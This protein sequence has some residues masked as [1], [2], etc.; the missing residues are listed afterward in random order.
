MLAPIQNSASRSGLVWTWHWRKD[1]TL[2]EFRDF[3]DHHLR[4]VRGDLYVA[5]PKALRRLAA[6]LLT[7]ADV[8]DAASEVSE[9]RTQFWRGKFGLSRDP[10]LSEAREALPSMNQAVGH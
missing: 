8:I 9:R 5:S 1:H 7:R 10:V 2:N 4:S 3:S 6:L